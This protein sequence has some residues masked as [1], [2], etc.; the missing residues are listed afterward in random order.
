MKRKCICI[1][2]SIFT[3]L[4]IFSI[5]VHAENNIAA[6]TE[7]EL[8]HIFN[9]CIFEDNSYLYKNE[10]YENISNT[11]Y[12]KQKKKEYHNDKN[13]Y[14]TITCHYNNISTSIQVF[15][16][17]YLFSYSNGTYLFDWCILE[18]DNYKSISDYDYHPSINEINN[19][20]FYLYN[21]QAARINKQKHT[22]PKITIDFGKNN[23]DC[24][25]T[26][27]ITRKNTDIYEEIFSHV[28]YS[29]SNKN[30]FKGYTLSYLYDDKGTKIRNKEQLNKYIDNLTEDTTLYVKLNKIKLNKCS[31]LKYI[32]KKN[33]V[34]IKG[35]KN[36]KADG[37]EIM[38]S[39][40]KSFANYKL[41][42]TKS[43]MSKIKKLPK[44]KYYIKCRY[45]KKDITN[46]MIH[47]KWSKTK[48]ITIK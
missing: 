10:T 39:K 47:S 19:S 5:S 17:S 1:I 36:N 11:E 40:N 20:D 42:I 21:Y 8:I 25:K 32:I 35:K 9:N 26:I 28:K 13:N 41:L 48:I 7:D 46:N 24:S 6:K 43:S 12:I 23:K 22:N 33:K 31:N 29:L 18:N 34:T 3:L 37:M 45:F 14:I 16:Y 15:K 44:G 4:N 38:Y 2:L 27:T 30:V